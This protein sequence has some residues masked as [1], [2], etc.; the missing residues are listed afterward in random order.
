MS[1]KAGISRVVLTDQVVQV[2]QERILDRVYEPGARLNIDALSRELDVSSSPIREA[3]MRLAADGLVVSSSFAGFS[4]APVPSRDWFEQ[5]LAYRILT[6]G[7]AARQMA[8]RRP[9]AAIERMRR[10]LAAMERGRMGRKARDYLTANQADQAFHEAMLDGTGNEILARSVRDLHPHLHHARL[11]AKVPQEI[12]PVIAEHQAILAAIA[13]GDEDGAA[14]A[15]ERHLRA[16]WQR[17]D[18]WTADEP[19]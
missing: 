3:L 7:W 13:A 4:V 6:E 16:S 1:Q 5:L 10:S 11:F 18:G 2:L 14:G 12:A 9:A 8:R 17:Y 15:L 19:A